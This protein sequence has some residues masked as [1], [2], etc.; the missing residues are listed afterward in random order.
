MVENR[1][2][3]FLYIKLEVWDI[4]KVEKLVDNPSTFTQME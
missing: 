1:V 4:S 3:V 2:E